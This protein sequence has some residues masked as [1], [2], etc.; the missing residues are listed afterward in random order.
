MLVEEILKTG[1]FSPVIYQR[2]NSQWVVLMRAPF[3]DEVEEQ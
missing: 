1:D 2:T 3:F